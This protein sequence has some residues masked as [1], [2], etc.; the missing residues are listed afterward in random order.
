MEVMPEVFLVVTEI[1]DIQERM[2]MRFETL[3]LRDD[4][5]LRDMIDRL[6]N[7]TLL[8]EHSWGFNPVPPSDCCDF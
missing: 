5:C 1:G 7:S 3:E 4:A 8:D 2:G 6:E